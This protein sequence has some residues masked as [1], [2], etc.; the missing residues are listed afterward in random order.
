MEVAR[1]GILRE[2]LGF[3]RNDVAVVTNVASD[4]LGLHGVNSMDQLADV[5]AVVVEAVPRDGFA[6]LNADDDLV[7]AMRR[8]CSGGIVWFSLQPPGTKV[9]DF[10]DEHCRRGE[11]AVVLEPTDKGDMIVIR[12]GRRS[13]QLAWAHLLPSTFGGAAKVNVANA[14]AAAGA[15][16][17]AG[18]PLH[19]IRQ[20]LSTFT[21]SYDLSPGRMNL[22]DINHLEVLVDYC[23][24]PPGMR[25]LGDFVESYTAQKA[26]K[27]SRIAMVG[28]PG[29]R[30]DGDIREMGSIAADHFDVLVVREDYPLR[31]RQ[32]GIAAKLVMEGAQARMAEGTARCRQ[33]EIVCDELA[34]V[35]D[36]IAS[37]KTGDLVVLCV[38]RHQSVMDVLEK[39]ANQAQV[40]VQGENGSPTTRSTLVTSETP[41][42]L[43]RSILP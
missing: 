8:R 41:A 25:L 23:H 5:K 2:G 33:V 17:A 7:R 43:L 13:M 36:C 3:D 11:R 6:V 22:L 34:A 21:T 24:N 15:A 29:D 39:I 20:G 42:Q 12:H 31:G 32:P 35:R 1:G 4:H 30:R 28:V 14:M 19:A 26:A 16:F 18:A 9:R 38:Q 40:G 37:A 10:V 27:S